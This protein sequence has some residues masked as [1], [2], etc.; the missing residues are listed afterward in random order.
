MENSTDSSKGNDFSGIAIGSTADHLT[1]F[2]AVKNLAYG[3]MIGTRMGLTGFN[4]GDDDTGRNGRTGFNGF[5]FDTGSGKPGTQLRI[6]AIEL[7]VI[8]EPFS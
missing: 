5:D 2:F 3:K 7:N 6:G 8:R 4:T 1:G